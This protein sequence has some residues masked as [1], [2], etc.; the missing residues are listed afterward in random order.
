MSDLLLFFKFFMRFFRFVLI[1]STVFSQILLACGNLLRLV[2]LQLLLIHLE[3]IPKQQS[4]RK[5]PRTE[6]P[7]EK[8]K[9]D[10]LQCI[11]DKRK[12]TG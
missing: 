11:L 1:V 3:I 12:P 8:N 4:E 2:L 5:A 6:S 9:A 7:D 10:E